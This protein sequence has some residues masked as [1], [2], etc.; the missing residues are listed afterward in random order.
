MNKS[1]ISVQ[2][3]NLFYGNFQAL[4]DV[5]LEIPANMEIG[6]AHV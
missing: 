5:N 1:K 6:R 2:D 3:L 4:Y